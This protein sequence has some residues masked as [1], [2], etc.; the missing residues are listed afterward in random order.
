MNKFGFLSILISLQFLAACGEKKQLTEMHDNTAQMNQ[1]TGSMAQTTIK[2]DSSISQMKTTTDKVADV[3]GQ[4]NE[5]MSKVVITA[6]QTAALMGEVYDTGRQGA[7]LDVRKKLFDSI[8]TDSSLDKK[9]VHAAEYFLAFEFQLW[10]SLSQDNEADARDRLRRDALTELFNH[11]LTV[12]HFAEDDLDPFASPDLQFSER[13]QKKNQMAVFNAIA[14]AAH[15]TNRKSER[16]GK[17]E[18]RENDS[19][20][21]LIKTGLLAGAQIRKGEKRIEDFPSYVDEVLKNEGLALRLLKARYNVLGV[22][23]LARLTPIADS[24]WQGARLKYLGKAWSLN[25]SDLNISQV[26]LYK[27]HLTEA[28]KAKSL[29]AE[30]GIKIQIDPSLKKIYEK[31]TVQTFAP[32]AANED[33]N[34]S[35]ERKALVDSIYQY[36]GSK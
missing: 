25:L 26:R 21:E 7:A 28:A 6:E 8:M 27:A 2:M 20:Y 11:L 30:L 10:S 31:M 23:L 1:T 35:S 17:I 34:L 24:L 13:F 15:I 29:L 19:I 16:N 3:S 14:A 33:L 5:K 12:S 18:N 22:I 9:V 36:R 32:A 4:M